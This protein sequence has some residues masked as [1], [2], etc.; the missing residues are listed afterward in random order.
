MNPMVWNSF[1]VENQPTVPGMLRAERY[2]RSFGYRV[3]RSR[4]TRDFY[5]TYTLSGCGLF[6][7]GTD[8]LESRPGDITVIT[9]G[10][11]HL[12]AADDQGDWEFYW[13]H[14]TPREEWMPL[15]Q[16]PEQLKGIKGGHIGNDGPDTDFICALDRLVKYSRD[17]SFIGEKLSANALEEALLLIYKHSETGVQ[18]LDSR[19][20]HA[21]QLLS[22]KFNEPLSVPV[23]AAAVNLSPS[24]FAHLFK[25]QT[26][27]SVMDMLNKIRLQ[28]AQQL[29]AVSDKS[30]AEIAEAAGYGS[31]YYF[32]RQFT[33]MYGCPPAAYRKQASPSGAASDVIGSRRPVPAK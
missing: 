6:H 26:G 14:F 3:K 12:Y 30:V 28:H 16:L 19:I 8:V 18:R 1:T 21:I 4:G 20:G 25:Q 22:D 24:R 27:E 7:H 23:L 17:T 15:L 9:P 29:L 33:A 11:P 32:T 2:K 31:P 10:T 13:C 5:L